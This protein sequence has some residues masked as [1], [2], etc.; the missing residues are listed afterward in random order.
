MN[1]L[2]FSKEER[3]CFR[4]GYGS[5]MVPCC[6]KTIPC[7]E[8][9]NLFEGY[10]DTEHLV[11]GTIGEHHHCPKDAEEAANLISGG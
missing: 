10:E 6:L 4:I 9:D 5:R 2:P 8:Y 11:G 3:C 7:E 1:L